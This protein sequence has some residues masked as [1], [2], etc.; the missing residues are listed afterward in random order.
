[1]LV[2]E[3]MEK[4]TIE[5]KKEEFNNFLAEFELMNPFEIKNTFKAYFSWGNDDNEFP[6]STKFRSAGRGWG[7]GNGMGLIAWT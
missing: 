1:M 5:I 6:T 4:L 3:E 2:D 7:S